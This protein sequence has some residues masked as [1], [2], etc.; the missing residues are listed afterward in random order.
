MYQIP[1]TPPPCLPLAL[2]DVRQH[3]KQDVTDDDIM[4]ALYLGSAVDYAQGLCQKQ[5][6][7]GKFKLN[8]AAFPVDAISIF[9]GPIAGIVSI[10][11]Y[12]IAGVQ[13][14][15]SAANYRL[16][17]TGNIAKIDL[18]TGYSWPSTQDRADAVEIIYFAGYVA[19]ASFDSAANTISITNWPTLAV[20]DVVRLSNSGGA[21]PAGLK[22]KTDYY[23]KTIVSPG[24]YTLATSA[25]GALI[26]LTDVGTG[27][28][29]AGQS[30]IHFG[31]GELPGAIIGWLML[32]CATGF[33]HRGESVIVRNGNLVSLPYVD[34]LLD[35]HRL[36]M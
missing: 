3:V 21:L 6:V 18:T 36:F 8:L 13:Q 15:I 34:R 27:L 12:D 28:S 17:A 1:L 22:A 29:F 19:A 4:L 25:G 35:Q 10:R 16:D 31:D 26:D 30:G 23:V 9:H 32:R 20:N 2:A 7:A 24:V 33:D 5:F 11:Y 14:T